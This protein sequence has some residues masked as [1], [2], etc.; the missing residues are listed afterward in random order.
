MNGLFLWGLAS[1]VMTWG[2]FYLGFATCLLLQTKASV[3]SESNGFTDDW[4]GM[5]HW[6]ICHWPMVWAQLFTST[7][8]SGVVFHFLPSWSGIG[9]LGKYAIGGFVAQPF[10][11]K[12]LFLYGK[13]F[14][15]KL[16][17]PQL[18]PPTQPPETK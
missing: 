18:A 2:L 5:R 6:L 17:A 14:G 4:A 1:F 10:V 16:E 15:L 12:I 11:D 7:A 9:E 8:L 13:K 3:S